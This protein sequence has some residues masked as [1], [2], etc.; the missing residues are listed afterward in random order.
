MWCHQEIYCMTSSFN[1]ERNSLRVLCCPLH[2][3]K[4]TS[5]V[6]VVIL[7][8]LSDFLFNF[9]NTFGNQHFPLLGGSCCKR[10]RLQKLLVAPRSSAD[11]GCFPVCSFP[12]QTFHTDLLST[13]WFHQLFVQQFVSLAWFHLQT[14][15]ASPRLEQLVFA[16]LLFLFRYCPLLLHYGQ[17][18]FTLPWASAVST[19]AF[20]SSS[21]TPAF[22]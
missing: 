7:F 4:V 9:T 18:S 2:S 10:S 17:L 13:V 16:S 14:N 12:I 22:R 15:F 11:C 8:P 5:F 3:Q 19:F 20:T 6:G 21:S 1:I